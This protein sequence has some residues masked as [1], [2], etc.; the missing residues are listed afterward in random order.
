MVIRSGELE[1]MVRFCLIHNWMLPE[2]FEDRTVSQITWRDQHIGWMVTEAKPPM[3]YK[4]AEGEAL[5]TLMV[6]DKAYWLAG[7]ELMV[8]SV[9]A[10]GGI[11]AFGQPAELADEMHEWIVATIHAEMD[12]K[13]AMA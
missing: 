12:F 3:P 8:S 10:E 11:S 2:D 9:Y 1:D 4:F 7:D 6:G 13:L 5:T